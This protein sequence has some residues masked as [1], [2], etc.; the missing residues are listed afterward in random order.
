MGRRGANETLSSVQQSHA[1]NMRVRG[2]NLIHQACCPVLTAFVV[3][4]CVCPPT[5]S[6]SVPC[7]YVCRPSA[8]CGPHVTT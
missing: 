2:D 4:L 7:L 6:S 1:C 8:L 5:A 3:Q